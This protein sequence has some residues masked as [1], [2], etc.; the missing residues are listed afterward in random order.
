VNTEID[1]KY[2]T[3]KFADRSWEDII[4]AT[5]WWVH[6]YD[7]GAKIVVPCVCYECLCEKCLVCRPN[8][9]FICRQ[10]RY[11]TGDKIDFILQNTDN[12]QSVFFDGL[13]DEELLESVFKKLPIIEDPRQ[14]RIFLSKKWYREWAYHF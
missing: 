13:D 5:G 9:T 4:F 3:E 14:M 10:C 1:R 8:G 6:R 11:N 2:W 7:R 12:E